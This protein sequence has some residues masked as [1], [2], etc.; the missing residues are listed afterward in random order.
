MEESHDH[1][2]ML[3]KLVSPRPAANKL[4]NGGKG[5][6]KG[7]GDQRA[8]L[9]ERGESLLGSSKGRTEWQSADM[10]SEFGGL[11]TFRKLPTSNF[12]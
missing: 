6:E 2:H 8:A 4:R 5:K 1:P 12:R 11:P 7:G 10:C 9:S 3:D